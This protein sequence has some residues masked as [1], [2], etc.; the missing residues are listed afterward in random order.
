MEYYLKTLSNI[1]EFITDFK[2]DVYEMFKD[3]TYNPIGTTYFITGSKRESLDMLQ[4]IISIIDVFGI[5]VLDRNKKGFENWLEIIEYPPRL[6]KWDDINKF[7]ENILS[8]F[9]MAKEELNEKINLLEEEER[10]RLNEAF[11]CYIQELNYSAIVMSVSAIENRLFSLMISKYY[12][13]RLEELT[14]G[15]LIWEYTHNKEKYGNII[16]EKHE[17]LLDYC[18]IYRVFSVHPKKEK[19]NRSNTTAILCMSCS[20]LFDKNMKTKTEKTS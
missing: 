2:K 3:E 11:N 5:D 19:I 10:E 20:F 6:F 8:V 14:L 9:Q 15:Q 18:N 4:Q 12:D 1:E 16:P 17:P 7:F 13:K